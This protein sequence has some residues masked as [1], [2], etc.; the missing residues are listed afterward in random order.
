MELRLF[1]LD[2]YPSLMDHCKYRG[3]IRSCQNHI[4]EVYIIGQKKI[5]IINMQDPNLKSFC[6][7]N[8]ENLE[9]KKRED[10]KLLI[11]M[12]LLLASFC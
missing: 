11:N 7:I 8:S 9:I 10:H 4:K 6:Y 5:I 2:S 12:T 1:G 3:E